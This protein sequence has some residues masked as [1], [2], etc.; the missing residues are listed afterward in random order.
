MTFSRNL[1][2]RL[3][4]EEAAKLRED[5]GK[6]KSKQLKGI[7]RKTKLSVEILYNGKKIY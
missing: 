2:S 5:Y 7:S 1:N 3:S 6:L 4:V